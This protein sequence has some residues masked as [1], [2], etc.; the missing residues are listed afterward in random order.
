[1]VAGI[2][3]RC[4]RI[5]KKIQKILRIKKFYTNYFTFMA[6]RSG[7]MESCAYGSCIHYWSRTRINTT[8]LFF[9]LAQNNP[10]ARQ[11][12]FYNKTD[13]KG[14]IFQKQH[15]KTLV[16]DNAPEFCNEDLNLW[17]E[18]IGCKLYKTPPYHP[19]LNR[20]VETMVQ[21]LKMGLK[22]CSQ[23]KGKK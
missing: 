4:Q 13:S 23:Q 11:E 21:T 15:I 22:A 10:Y 9:T 19:Q 17:L 12:K 2:F 14:H 20:L 5:Y 1:M 3:T 7:A 8:T 16:S 6:Q 18:K